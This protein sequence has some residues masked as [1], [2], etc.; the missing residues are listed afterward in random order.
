MERN[1][2]KFLI[3]DDSEITRQHLSSIVSDLVYV[4]IEEAETG[5]DA[6]KL[7]E[8][9]IKDRK[10][11]HVVFLDINMPGMNGMEFLEWLSQFEG[12]SKKPYVV[13]VTAENKKQF[14]LDSI[15]NGAIDFIMKPYRIERIKK[16]LQKI[17]DEIVFK[18]AAKL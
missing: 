12:L 8:D 7:I 13:M 15:D 2:I 6:K 4:D 14:I 3:V 10:F 17:K 9:S 11:Y 1:Y 16:V 5:R 18:Q